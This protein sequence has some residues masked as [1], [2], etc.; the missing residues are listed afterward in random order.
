MDRHS[1]SVADKVYAALSSRKQAKL[2]AFAYTRIMGEPVKL[3]TDAEWRRDGPSMRDILKRA[4]TTLPT[5]D[6]LAEVE[7]DFG[8]HFEIGNNWMELLDAI[9][10]EANVEGGPSSSTDNASD[11]AAKSDDGD[12]PAAPQEGDGVEGLSDTGDKADQKDTKPAE[13]KPHKMSKKE[14]KAKRRKDKKKK[15][16]KGENTSRLC[17]LRALECGQHMPTI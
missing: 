6:D 16:A 8:A 4:D 9:K 7:E 2:S 11:A 10:Q 1:S 5:E 12:A 15:K 14:A 13:V 17:I 3:P